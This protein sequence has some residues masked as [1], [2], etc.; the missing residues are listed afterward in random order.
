MSWI[1][2]L[3]VSHFWIKIDIAVGTFGYFLNFFFFGRHVFKKFKQKG[4]LE[5]M[6]SLS[7]T[8]TRL[9]TTE[10][11]WSTCTKVRDDFKLV[12]LRTWIVLGRSNLLI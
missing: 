8:Y 10:I 7:R 6:A 11:I 12:L 3:R 5:E 2:Y 9:K 1:Y 4:L